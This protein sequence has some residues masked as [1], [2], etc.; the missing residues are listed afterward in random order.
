[1]HLTKSRLKQI[2]KEETEKIL[3]RQ[4]NDPIE[5]ISA[6]L[7][8][9]YQ[10][11]WEDHQYYDCP[12]DDPFT[13]KDES[14][15]CIEQIE[16]KHLTKMYNIINPMIMDLTLK[17]LE[18]LQ[19]SIVKEMEFNNN[20]YKE[21]HR[22][23][24][25]ITQWPAL[26]KLTNK[27]HQLLDGM[28]KYVYN[29]HKDKQEVLKHASPKT[30]KCGYIMGGPNAGSFMCDGKIIPKSA[31]ER[32][33]QREKERAEKTEKHYRK[34]IIKKFGDLPWDAPYPEEP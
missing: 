17:Q 8:I 7:R 13:S 29:V 34:K 33:K 18:N 30:E 31:Y 22:R 9:V 27:R 21:G 23:I 5:Y 24:I 2:I 12:K 28:I 32:T 10:K 25:D 6:Y 4:K 14:K 20:W 1:M 16:Q 3:Q 11:A 19:T 26:K 15:A